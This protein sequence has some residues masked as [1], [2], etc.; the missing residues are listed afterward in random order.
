[1][2]FASNISL[3]PQV[4]KLPA[5]AKTIFR[6]AFNA[7]FKEHGE[8]TAF[9]IA[10]AAVK[11]VYNKT[12]GRWVMKFDKV[13]SEGF[14]VKKIG[15][16][17]FV[18]GYLSTPHLDK[19]NDIVT[20]KAL[21]SMA[22]QIAGSELPFMIGLEHEH[23]LE[24]ARNIPIA[25]IVDSKMDNNGL[26]INTKVNKY[27]PGFDAIKG[28]LENGFLNAFS[29]EFSPIT[30]RYEDLDGQSIRVIDDL[31][32]GGAAYTG[33]P[34]NPH[35]TFT[36][37]LIKSLM[38][39]DVKK[40]VTAREKLRKKKKEGTGEFYAFPRLKK[41]PIFDA[42]HVRNAVAR[43]NQTQGMTAEEKATARR[44]I[45]RAAKKFGIDISKFGEKKTTTEEIRMPKEI[46]QE[47]AKP[48]EEK[49]QESTTEEAAE[50]AP[51]ETE[52]KPTE[53]APAEEKPAEEPATE[54]PAPAEE[55]PAEAPAE[56]G[57]TEP[58]TEPSVEEEAKSL[59]K[60][61]ATEIKSKAREIALKELRQ[62]L[63]SLKPE[64]R[65]LVAKEQKFEKKS[66][67]FSFTTAWK[68]AKEVN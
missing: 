7:S 61:L 46:K 37:V 26:W 6:K 59:G 50:A 32:F 51:E 5:K 39:E 45:L 17:F 15:D 57:G 64:S 52:E 11:R 40:V 19:V 36:D 34:A 22:S 47:E 68:N 60:L 35:C 3:P 20:W 54:E 65:V 12:G 21:E 55:T 48:E 63:K 24:D 14:E 30:W 43:F 67:P 31:E 29:I 62:E 44:K 13:Y 18:S 8:E 1:M 27:H 66:T 53:E 38:N 16:D 58:A 23:V 9:K 33:K 10:W 42:A 41:L 56:N 49:P 4:Q 2:P 28:S 25:Q